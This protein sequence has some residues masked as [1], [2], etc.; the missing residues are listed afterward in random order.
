M[1]T[2]SIHMNKQNKKRNPKPSILRPSN[3]NKTHEQTKK[4]THNK[5]PTRRSPNKPSTLGPSN[6]KI[7]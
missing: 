7:T 4:K 2:G 5:L 6:P 3:P 1:Y